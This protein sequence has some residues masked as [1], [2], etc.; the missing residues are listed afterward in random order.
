MT[1]IVAIP[2]N[3]D[4]LIAPTFMT[5]LETKL[6]EIAGQPIDSTFGEEVIEHFIDLPGVITSDQIERWKTLKGHQE[7]PD[8]DAVRDALEVVQII[9]D[10]NGEYDEKP[11]AIEEEAFIVKMVYSTYIFQEV[12]A[13]T[14]EEAVKKVKEPEKINEKQK[15]ELIMNLERDDYY[16]EA[17]ETFEELK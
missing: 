16:D 2:D 15:E 13:K 4:S 1:D 6:N 3:D 17:Y 8:V 7:I 11:P 10:G 9:T 5:P 12:M 14:Q